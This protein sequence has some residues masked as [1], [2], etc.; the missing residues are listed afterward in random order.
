MKSSPRKQVF[1]A[2]GA[3][4]LIHVALILFCAVAIPAMYP[5]DQP[6]G[7]PPPPPLQLTIEREEQPKPEPQLVPAPQQQTPPP[8]ART[9]DRQHSDVAPDDPAFQSHQNTLAAS[10]LPP[11]NNDR[12]AATQDGREMPFFEFDTQDYTAGDKAS[13]SAGRRAPPPSE[14][15]PQTQQTP[16]PKPER[17]AAAATPPP[18]QTPPP[19]F[20]T[21]APTPAPTPPAR[22]E[23]QEFAM[24]TQQTPPPPVPTPPNAQVDPPRPQP[25]MLTNVR[26]RAQPPAPPVR[27]GDPGYKPQTNKTKI[28]GGIT[29]HGP[30]SPAALD[31]PLGRYQKVVQDAIGSRWYF[32]VERQA[33]VIPIGL[34]RFKFTVNAEGKIKNIRVLEGDSTG[35]LATVTMNALLDATIPPMPPDLVATLPD[36]QLDYDSFTFAHL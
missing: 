10:E 30:S 18:Q 12:T 19:Q 9:L 6:G 14:P 16:P 7:L 13:D 29:N 26:P 11:Q 20:R 35:T 25:Q 4:L 3:A 5:P 31:T 17:Q 24:L 34:V 22:A 8:Y 2:L 15:A 23:P 33:D 27:P 28:V 32:Y 36:H 21:E 1:I